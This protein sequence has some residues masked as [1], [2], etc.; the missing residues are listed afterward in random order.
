[1]IHPF[2]AEPI[3]ERTIYGPTEP[4]VTF[5]MPVF[6]QEEIIKKN[7]NSL[8]RSA[9]IPF[10]LIVIDDGSNDSTLGC[11]SLFLRECHSPL[12]TQSLIIKN[13]VPIYET[14]C[15]N[16]GFRLSRTEFIIEVQSD[17]E[18]D[19]RGF[20]KRMIDA[21]QYS[22]IGTVSGR[23]VH[24]FSLL[25]NRR[26]WFK[27]PF[28]KFKSKVNPY[29]NCIGLVG[30]RVFSG[31]PVNLG[32]TSLYIGETNSRGPWL[33]RKSDLER[34][35]YL[36]EKHFFLGNDDHDFNLR[37]FNSTQRC[38]AY[39]PVHQR[40]LPSNGSTRKKRTGLNLDIY[41][42]LLDHKR[43]SRFFLQYMHH[44]RPF[45][46]SAEYHHVSVC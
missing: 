16:Q 19:D 13:P 3:V 35:D 8:I 7:L 40:S 45:L 43:G 1:M 32:S 11:L 29:Y 42:Y 39:V 17:I 12:L 18:I 46:K 30:A 15:D 22:F 21:A 26:S 38:A 37:L 36:D 44:Y 2:Q 23:H 9:S 28:Y 6:N 41:N 25:D 24:P 27:Y 33:V 20:D 31:S 5:V 34:F 10:D 14:A 4:F